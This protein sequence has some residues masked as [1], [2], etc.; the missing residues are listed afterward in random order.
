MNE[1]PATWSELIPAPRWARLAAATR[2]A[3]AN[4]QPA[5]GL[6]WTP[7]L[8]LSLAAAVLVWNQDTF[9][10]PAAVPLAALEYLELLENLELL[11]DWDQL[12]VPSAMEKVLP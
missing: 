8:A 12:Q 3:A 5:R 2:R 1:R 6:F 9:R 4:E 10:T 11:E 7:A